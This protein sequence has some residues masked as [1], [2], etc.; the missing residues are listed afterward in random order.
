MSNF[1]A[2]YGGSSASAG[3]SPVS[4]CALDT[5]SSRLSDLGD[6]LNKHIVRLRGVSDRAHGMEAP[7]ANAAADKPREVPNGYVAGINAKIDELSFL[8]DMGQGLDAKLE[9]TT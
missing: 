7:P 9:L 6:A 3:A 2:S 5:I 1:P 8:V 4:A